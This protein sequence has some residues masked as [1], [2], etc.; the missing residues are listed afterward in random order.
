MASP[1]RDALVTDS[2]QCGIGRKGDDQERQSNTPWLKS[3]PNSV[4]FDKRNIVMKVLITSLSVLALLVAVDAC[5]SSL[6]AEKFSGLQWIAGLRN[7]TAGYSKGAVGPGPYRLVRFSE[8]TAPIPI[9]E[10]ELEALLKSH[11]VSQL[12][13]GERAWNSMLNL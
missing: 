6:H 12:S 4:R 1:T 10:N 2:G 7:A 5:V 11:Q 13:F 9:T 3:H 8:G